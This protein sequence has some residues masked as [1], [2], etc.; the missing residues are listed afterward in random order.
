MVDEHLDILAKQIRRDKVRKIFEKTRDLVN[1]IIFHELKNDMEQL[2]TLSGKKSI[3]T[4]K[5]LIKYYKTINN[6]GYFPKVV[7]V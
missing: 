6:N 7:M 4:S 2:Y 5:L 1:K 3:P